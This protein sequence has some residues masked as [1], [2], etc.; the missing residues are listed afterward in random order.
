[1]GFEYEELFKKALV[2][3]QYSVELEV[4]MHGGKKFSL[5][6]MKCPFLTNN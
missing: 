6:R 1:M 4:L 3:H 2:F 5:K